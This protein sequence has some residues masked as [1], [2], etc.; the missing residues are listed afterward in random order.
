MIIFLFPVD[1]P[2]A[3]IG[4]EEQVYGEGGGEIPSLASVCIRV[5]SME[6]P[7]PRI[8]RFNSLGSRLRL[9]TYK[10]VLHMV[11]MSLRSL[12]PHGGGG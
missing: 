5:R 10:E 11:M 6:G 1:F 3:V 8:T 4:S 2:I 12:P 7:L 9:R